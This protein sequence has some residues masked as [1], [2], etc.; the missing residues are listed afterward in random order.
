MIEV[1][2][3]NAGI[4]SANL[5]SLARSIAFLSNVFL[6]TVTLTFLSKQTLRKALTFSTVNVEQSAK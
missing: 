1:A 6:T 2:P 5:L 4:N 3:F